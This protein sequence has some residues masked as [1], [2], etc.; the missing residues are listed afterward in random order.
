MATLLTL[1]TPF[2]RPTDMEGPYLGVSD[3]NE[4]RIRA[5]LVEAVDLAGNSA[6]SLPRRVSIGDTAARPLTATSGVVDGFRGS[7]GVR[8]D[9]HVDELAGGAIPGGNRSLAGAE[10][11]DVGALRCHEDRLRGN[12]EG[13]LE[14]H[15]QIKLKIRGCGLQASFRLG[16]P[17]YGGDDHDQDGTLSVFIWLE[18]HM[19]LERARVP[20]LH[21]VL[22]RGQEPWEICQQATEG[23]ITAVNIRVLLAA[24]PLCDH[25]EVAVLGNWPQTRTKATISGQVA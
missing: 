16:I 8:A 12:D 13:V 9:N 20:W 22:P 21:S 6:G 4:L 18:P 24:A 25:T 17:G 15:A 1:A 23:D 10:D 11:V 19:C 14:P 7:A 2:Y 3:K 5:P